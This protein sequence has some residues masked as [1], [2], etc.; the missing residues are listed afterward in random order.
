MIKGSE[1][2]GGP[3]EMSPAEYGA[4][5]FELFVTVLTFV[6]VTVFTLSTSIRD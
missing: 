1:T 2:A 5:G 6:Y 3:Q 4:T